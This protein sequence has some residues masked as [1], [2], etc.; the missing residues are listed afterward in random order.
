MSDA[1]EQAVTE[2]GPSRKALGRGLA[3]LIPGAG[4]SP[5][6]SSSV[7]SAAGVD[8]GLRTLAIER[9][10]PNPEQPRK[11]FEP[12]ALAEL[13]ESI[14]EHGVLQPIVVRRRDD[15]YEIVAGERRW[16]AAAK[17]GLREVPA[18]IKEFSDATVLAV[19]LV[20]NI[21]RRDLDPLEEADAY[22]RLVEEYEL[23]QSDVAAAVGKSRV[24]VT[25]ALR[26]LKLPEPVLN[27]LGAGR[28]TAGHARALMMLDSATDME[29]MA[30]EAV[31]R[32]LSV[33]ELEHRAK[34][35][36]ASAKKA[37]MPA[38]SKSEL[39]L[40]QKLQQALGTKVRLHER[41][42]KG[43]IEIAFHSLEHLD[44][45]VDKILG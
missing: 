13:A 8:T 2:N 3:A 44:S 17:A 4:S 31:K 7:S 22:R 11:S 41:G 10:R 23:S 36:K 27:H 39:A 28:I 29:R 38:R 25:N 21:Q 24:T 5:S 1:Q 15:G 18:L 19:A 16:R 45:V 30:E 35:M 26:L 37:A 34:T 9:I 6:G 40:E 43:R 33:R 12:E 42:G 14:E 20:E 32:K